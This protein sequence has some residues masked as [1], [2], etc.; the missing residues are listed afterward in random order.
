MSNGLSRRQFLKIMASCS[1]I[2]AGLGLD[3]NATAQMPIDFGT[4]QPITGPSE[5]FTQEAMFYKP[6]GEKKIECLL[7]PRQ[8]R[9]I[10]GERGYCGVRENRAGKYYTMVYSRVCTAHNDPIEKKPFYHFLPG[11]TAFSL[12][13]AG[14]N[15]EC[16]FCQ[17][18]QISQ[19]RPE[20]VQS[21]YLP[22][23]Q[24]ADLARRESSPTIAYTYSEP[25]IFYEY[26]LATATEGRR[27]GIKS[28]M[29]S[30]GFI[31]Q[32]PMD[33]LL[34]TMDAVKIDLKAFTEKFYREV[35]SGELKPVLKTMELVKKRGVWL[36]I[37]VLILPTLN[38]SD[39]EITNLCRWVKANLGKETPVHFIR[40]YPTYKIKNLPPT[41]VSTLEKAYQIATAEGL[42]F[43]YVGNVPGHPMDQTR[44]P[45][46]RNEVI[47]RIGFYD[48][49][50]LLKNGLCPNCDKPLPGVWT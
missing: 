1:V 13:T 4:G 11:T 18:W 2:G 42:F 10:D 12:A 33:K 21:V 40:F 34:G 28:V 23:D 16:R 14:C 45:H 30:N 43:P 44:C 7:C 6:L 49:K 27:H 31:N 47:R 37:V 38:D 15:I 39:E 9:I 32:E 5:K 50:C 17:N 3:S 29:V 36:E 46:C 25:V 41:P 48:V 20:Q 8:C 35:C 24:V 26:M 22:P 19:F